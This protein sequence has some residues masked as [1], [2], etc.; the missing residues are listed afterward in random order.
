MKRRIS[1]LFTAVILSALMISGCGAASDG[2]QTMQAENSAG[3][4]LSKSSYAAEGNDSAVADSASDGGN[5]QTGETSDTRKL[6]RTVS[7]SAETEQYSE[8]VDKVNADVTKLGG[9]VESCNETLSGDDSASGRYI[10]MTLRVPE[11]KADQLIKNVNDNSNI[12]SRS[13]N[14]EDVTLQY[15]DVESQKKALQAEEKRLTEMMD[16]A[17][18]MTDIIAIEDKLAEV[19]GNIDSLESQIRVYDNQIDYTT[20]DLDIREVKSY[21]PTGEG[22]VGERI[23]SGFTKSLKAVGH[24]FV[25]FFVWFVS[26]LPV[27][28]VWALIIFLIVTI[29]RICAKRH[30]KKVQKQMQNKQHNMPY[31]FYPQNPAQMNMQGMNPNMQGMNPNMQNVNM[32]GMNPNM[33]NANTPNKNSQPLNAA[34]NEMKKDKDE[35]KSDGVGNSGSSEK[36]KNE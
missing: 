18:N 22:S 6:I 12:T 1:I 15:T 4:G 11:D 17:Q 2:P 36:G 34:A 26:N 23:A 5:A 31:V 33:Q 30:S 8:L 13:E 3:N 21:T 29:S 32:Q 27:I 7:I 9:Y 16:D 14:T 19:R 24:G 35:Q 25:N 28:A 10:Y 20:I